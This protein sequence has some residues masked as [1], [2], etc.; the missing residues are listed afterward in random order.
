MSRELRSLLYDGRPAILPVSIHMPDLVVDNVV[1]SGGLPSVIAP[2]G[3]TASSSGK[4]WSGD[5]MLR[6]SPVSMGNSEPAIMSEFSSDTNPDMEDELCQFQ[7]LQV[8][9]LPL[10]TTTEME[11]IASPSHY[12]APAVPVVPSAVSSAQVSPEPVREVY[13]HGTPDIFLTYE[14]SP[15]TS[16]YVPATS[17]VTPALSEGHVQFLGTESL[18]PG[19][20]GGGSGV[21]E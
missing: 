7:P 8:A 1:S 21:Y 12:P 11:V 19:G 4:V 18:S 15:D 6:A 5:G 14:P 10:S 20:G 17:P 3:V 9:V 16:L 2:P 13:S